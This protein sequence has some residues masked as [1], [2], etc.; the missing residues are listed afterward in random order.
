MP[1]TSA[2]PRPWRRRCSSSASPRWWRCYPGCAPVSAP[3]RSPGGSPSCSLPPE[4]PTTGAACTT[5]GGPVNWRRCLPRTL[6]GGLVVGFLTGLLGIGG[7]SSSS[8]WWSSC[9]VVDGHGRRHVPGDRR[10]H[11]TAGFA[12]HAGDAPL[13]VPVTVAFTAAAAVAALTAGRLGARLGTARLRRWSA[14]LV[15]AVA[16]VILVQIA[17]SLLVS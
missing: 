11:S 17:G 13:D 5:D 4:Q 10:G 12:A 2:F 1:S 8:R 15:V 14:C 9:W 16:A 6:A 7:G 3:V